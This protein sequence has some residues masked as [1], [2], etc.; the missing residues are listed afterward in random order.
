MEMS[1]SLCSSFHGLLLPNPSSPSLPRL[2]AAA[3]QASIRPRTPCFPSS[4]A[5]QSSVFS[6][7]S[8]AKTVLVPLR[9]AGSDDGDGEEDEE[10]EGAEREAPAPPRIEPVFS[11]RTPYNDITI[12]EV[13]KRM[14]SDLAGSKLLLLDDSGE[15]A[16]CRVFLSV[17]HCCVLHILLLVFVDSCSSLPEH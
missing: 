3:A 11:M 9:P 16:S 17:V 13:P 14:N 6:P 5:S 2:R 10:G 4:L 7:V 15:L 1:S 12:L 8:A